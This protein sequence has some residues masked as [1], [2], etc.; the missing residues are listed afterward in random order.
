MVKTVLFSIALLCAFIVNAQKMPEDY[1]DEA[2]NY[3]EEE[4]YTKALESYQYLIENHPKNVLYPRAFYNVGYIHFVL[5][6][7]TEALKIFK[8][9]L[10]SNFNEKEDLG[11][12]IMSDPFTNYRHR[13]CEIISKIYFNNK[14]YESALKYFE[15]AD[16]AYPY[17]SFCGFAASYNEIQTAARYGFIYYKLK[18][19]QKAL[20]K[21]LPHAFTTY[22]DNDLIIKYLKELLS[23]EKDL[24][25]KLELA[26]KDLYF[27]EFGVG[28]LE[29]N[30]YYLNFYDVKIAV[31][32]QHYYDAENFDHAMIIDYIR[33]SAF[34]KMI[35]SL[36]Q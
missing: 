25:S 11:G 17:L 28:E 35:V 15:L 2:S 20:K 19:P 26:I 34:Y 24:I 36:D 8:A 29:F 9:I 21:L 33:S 13:S 18:Q 1:F 4:A 10:E 23:T 27:K 32:N 7:D 12:G 30:Q 22:T 5:E 3:Y 16:T 14:E 31:P 6:N